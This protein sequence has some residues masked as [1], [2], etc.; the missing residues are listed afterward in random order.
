MI[1][2]IPLRN[3]DFNFSTSFVVSG[4]EYFSRFTWMPRP[5]MFLMDLG[6]AE[7]DISLSGVPLMVGIPLNNTIENIL[8][9]SLF[10][11]STDPTVEIPNPTQLGEEVNLYHYQQDV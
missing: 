2:K 11:Q 10:L 8:P 9:G 3:N 6:L 5:K 1:Q 7:S 4:V